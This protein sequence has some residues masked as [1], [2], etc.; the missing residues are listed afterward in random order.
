VPGFLWT[1]DYRLAFA[2][3]MRIKQT[4]AAMRLAEI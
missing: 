3:A 1:A 4:A 2:Q